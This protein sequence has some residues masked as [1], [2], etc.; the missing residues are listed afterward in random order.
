MRIPAIAK[1]ASVS[2]GIIGSA[3]FL[4]ILL[5]SV[6]HETL[7][8]K[9]MPMNGAFQLYNPLQ[10]MAAGEVIGKDFD[11]FHGAGTLLV[12]YPLYELFGGDLH[13]SE[14][15]RKIMS[16]LA[17]FLCF[18]LCAAAWRIPGYLASFAACAVLVLGEALFH[19]TTA[20]DGASILGV[21]SCQPVLVLP[22]AVLL[23]RKIKAF[24]QP[25]LFH[26]TMATGLG[27]SI[28]ISTEQGL[29]ALAVHGLLI[30]AIPMKAR[31]RAARMVAG[32]STGVAALLVFIACTVLVSGSHASESLKFLLTDLPKE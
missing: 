15:S 30:L 5:L 23:A 31:T 8:F 16:P 20:F 7:L 10:R 27:L 18:H 12:H 9:S 4:G 22:I 19:G 29:A 14:I 25:V 6:F 17:F 2:L 24:D 32:A 28:F 21:R 3:L 26:L 1:K 11:F 13:A